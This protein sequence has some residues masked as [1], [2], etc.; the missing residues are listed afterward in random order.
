MPLALLLIA[1]VIGIVG[2]ASAATIGGVVPHHALAEEMILEFYERLRAI[3][4]QPTRVILLGPDHFNAGKT[5]VTLSGADWETPSGTLSAD[6]ELMRSLLNAQTAA[7]QDELFAREHSITTHIPL[8]RKYLKNS[9]ILP[10]MIQLR[11]TDIHLLAL[12]KQLLEFL[13]T[14]G[15]LILSMDFSHYKTPEEAD[16]EDAKSLA[17][18]KN[19]TV[20][21]GLDIDCPRGAALFLGIMR[22]LGST[23]LSVL[24]HENSGRLLGNA[25]APSTSYF[26]LIFR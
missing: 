23:N 19:F 1:Q 6:V 5:P 9:T 7:R 24:R 11:V 18:I 17:S 16:V 12:R 21:R 3:D 8:I 26:T 10:L 2:Y 4:P 25:D 20:K 22:E 15:L 14:G 13:Q